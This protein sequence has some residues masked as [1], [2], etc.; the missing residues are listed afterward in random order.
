VP[1]RRP[2]Y[3]LEG[4]R[5][6]AHDKWRPP[7]FLDV[8]KRDRRPRAPLSSHRHRRSCLY[9]GWRQQGR[10]FDDAA[11]GNSD[12]PTLYDF[13]EKRWSVRIPPG[14]LPTEIKQATPLNLRLSAKTSIELKTDGGSQWRRSQ[15]FRRARLQRQILNLKLKAIGIFC[16]AGLFLSLLLATYGVDL[17]RDFF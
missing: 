6:H 7:R 14:W 2:R 12:R 3:R 10:R 4:I 13:G 17:S 1:V 15:V 11:M 5:R 8:G 9:Q 16:A